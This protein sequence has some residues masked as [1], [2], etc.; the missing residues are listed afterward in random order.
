M[1]D[2]I[3]LFTYLLAQKFTIKR[4]ANKADLVNGKIPTAQL[5]DFVTPTELTNQLSGKQDVIDDLNTIRQ[6]A[7]AGASTASSLPNKA[8]LVNG[9]V[10]ENQLP[11][12]VN[13]IDQVYTQAE[14]NKLTQLKEITTQHGQ[15]NINKITTNVMGEFDG[16][17]YYHKREF[18]L[19]DL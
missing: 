18:N 8:D 12:K 17:K 10:K 19:I 1:Y 14:K 13:N 3:D 9:K 16:V 7:N 6:N 5:P 4:T 11:D 2:Q 15:L